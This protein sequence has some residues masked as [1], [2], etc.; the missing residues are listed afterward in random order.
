[1]PPIRRSV[2][3]A[4]AALTWALP[5]RGQEEPRAPRPNLL[6]L[7]ADDQRADTVGAWGNPFI[8][9]PNIDRLAGGG[10][11]FRRAYC[12]GSMHGAVCVPSRA[13]LHTGRDYHGLDMND[14]NGATTLGQALGA[15]GYRTFATGKWHNGRGS[16]QRSFQR[17][18]AVM[19]GGMSNHREV[20]V[21]DLGEAGF[22]NERTGER[23]SSELFADAAIEFLREQDGEAPFF[24]YV[25]FTAP[26]D[27]RDPPRPF[28]ERYLDAPPPL[29]RNFL[30]Q[31]P[32]DNGMLVLRDENLGPWPRTRELIED[33][34]AEYYGL[35][36]HL[37]EQVGRILEALEATGLAEET[38]V[39]YAA[40]HGLAVGSH[41][42]LG[43]QSLYEH[44]MRAP[45]ILSGP[46]IPRGTASTALVYLLDL[47]PT[48][49]GLCGAPGDADITG[50]DLSPLWRGEAEGV[51]DTL[52]LS[53]TDS[54]RA[55]M[56]GRWKLIRYPRVDVT[57]LFDLASDPDEL[58]DLSARPEHAARVAALWAELERWQAE[59]GDDAPLVVPEDRRVPRL[60]DLT[61]TARE[62][63][64]WQPRWIRRKY[65]GEGPEPLSPR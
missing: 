25:A 12:M 5:A 46:G 18:E 36:T 62:P 40:D 38:V 58:L 11:S 43:K 6:L 13:M 32:F 8:S 50:R 35:V 44:S 1:M 9:T 61:G 55:V 49:L 29:P 59:V 52:Y 7:F 48:L 47:Y 10:V 51:R 2:L 16:F 63:D 14:F 42:L 4:I 60:R 54:Q 33:Q 65:F 24:C 28:A 21:V 30:P 26:H 20:P 27:P 31:H 57:Q 56:D 45:L 17:G 41:G 34:L 19:F 3:L 53:L 37:D 39:V 64:R 23:H 15:A 22:Q